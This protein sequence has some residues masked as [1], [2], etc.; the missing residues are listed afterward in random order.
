LTEYRKAG[1]TAVGSFSRRKAF[2]PPNSTAIESNVKL[3]TPPI[4]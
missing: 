2:S 1:N 4:P 3:L